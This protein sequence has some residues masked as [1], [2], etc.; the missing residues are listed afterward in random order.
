MSGSERLDDSEIIEDIETIFNSS[1]DEN[2]L[3]ILALNKTSM[4]MKF[5]NRHDYLKQI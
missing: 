4:M 3:R 5:K 2:F 1:L